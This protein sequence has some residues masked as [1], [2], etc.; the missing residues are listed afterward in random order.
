MNM[1]GI[2]AKYIISGI[3]CIDCPG[4]N[5]LE[6]FVEV[7]GSEIPITKQHTDKVKMMVKTHPEDYIELGEA[8]KNGGT[9]IH[10]SLCYEGD[11]VYLRP[12]FTLPPKEDDTS[13]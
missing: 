2:C 13:Q 10:L 1:T 3:P 12:A 8:L 6:C 7:N 5:Q 9:L 4:P 11:D